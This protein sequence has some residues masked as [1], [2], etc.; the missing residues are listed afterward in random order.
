MPAPPKR[1]VLLL[2]ASL[3]LAAPFASADSGGPDSPTASD[4]SIAPAYPAVPEA[5]RKKLIQVGWDMVDTAFVREHLAEMEEAGPFDGMLLWVRGKRADGKPASSEHAWDAAPWDRASFRDA[6]DDLAACRSSRLTD[7]FVRFNCTPG[8]LDW[9]DD[10]GWAALAE[11]A[12]ILAWVARAGGLKG[13]CLDPESYG[14]R[15]YEYRGA[16]GRSFAETAALARKRGAEVMR[17]VAAEH[18]T[19]TLMSFWLASLCMQA[20]RTAVPDDVLA[21][22]AY[23]LWPA[24][25][26]G[27]LD[28]APP[29]MALVDGNE[30]GYYIEGAEYHAVAS[31]MRSLTGPAFSLIAPEN[32]GKYRS[33][34]QVAFGFYLDMYVNPEGNRYYRGPKPD[35]TRL[36]RLRDNLAAA[37]DASDQYVWVYGEQSRWWPSFQWS[38]WGKERVAS[39][40]G[41]GRLWEEALPGLTRTL[42]R[43]RNPAEA[44]REEVAALRRRGTIANLARNADFSRSE[45]DLPAEVGTWQAESSKG[46]FLWD[47]EGGGA[48]R[49]EDVANGCF[50]QKHP[51]KPG[52][53]YFVEAA[54]RTRGGAIPT[55]V[56]RWQDAGEAWASW[57]LDATLTFGAAGEDGWRR[58]GGP[59]T[60]PDG[61]GFLVILAGM[62]CPAGGGGATWIDDL[63]LYRME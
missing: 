37:L 59:A 17:A 54:A 19:M 26:N 5:P 57:H 33:Q 52:E 25:L 50:I 1:T 20:G 61:V 46:R 29:A 13:I 49:M 39:S 36:D 35:G 9:A 40:V 47:P 51:V 8:T 12:G 41:K 31:H 22:E 24:F 43:V 55:L 62:K 14:E 23:G 2:A 11:K 10:A 6:V 34:M 3:A 28:A 63:G 48:A 56:V 45:G 21:T 58:A 4:G 44:A 42:A 53:T 60:V 15:Q 32:R 18:P 38:P 27:L 30:N 7:N 16:G